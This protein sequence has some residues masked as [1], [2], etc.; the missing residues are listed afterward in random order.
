MDDNSYV[1]MATTAATI[2]GTEVDTSGLVLLGV[3]YIRSRVE[4]VLDEVKRSAR[5][6]LKHLEVA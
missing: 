3:G 2:K 4:A 1:L 5:S 6:D